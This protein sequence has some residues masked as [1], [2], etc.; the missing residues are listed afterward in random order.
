VTATPVVV[1]GRDGEEFA[2]VGPAG[3]EVNRRS[4]TWADNA[5]AQGQELAVGAATVDAGAP[6]EWCL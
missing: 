2:R 5:R 4:P 6:P 3:V 1:V